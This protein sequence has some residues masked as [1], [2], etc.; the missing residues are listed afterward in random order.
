MKDV[1]KDIQ[2][3]GCFQCTAHFGFP[4]VLRLHSDII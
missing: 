3:L 4:G 1:Q 2:T